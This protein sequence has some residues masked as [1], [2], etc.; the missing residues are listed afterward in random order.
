MNGAHR[1][2]HAAL[3]FTVVL[4]SPPARSDEFDTLLAKWKNRAASAPALPA[5][6]PDLL[7]QGGASNAAAQQYWSTMN[8]GTARTALWP[9]LPL[10]TASGSVTASFARLAALAAA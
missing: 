9:D 5:N 10:G 4:L 2:W 6:D 1:P 8:L 3:L 7:A